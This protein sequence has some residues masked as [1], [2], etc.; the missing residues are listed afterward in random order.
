MLIAHHL[1]IFGRTGPYRRWHKAAQSLILPLKSRIQT[2]AGC[3]SGARKTAH[4]DQSLYLAG[5][6]YPHF[7]FLSKKSAG[8]H[9][10]GIGS[11]GIVPSAP[12]CAGWPY[13]ETAVS[14]TSR[15][16]LSCVKRAFP[17]LLQELQLSPCHLS[18]PG[19]EN[20]S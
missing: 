17:F 5:T 3:S 6:S 2:S 16:K 15:S 8:Q 7:L 1:V 20:C 18:L 19:H 9:S 14:R 11:M 13:S 10:K 12:K 4:E